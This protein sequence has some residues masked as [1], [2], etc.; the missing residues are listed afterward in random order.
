MWKPNFGEEKHSIIP[1]ISK[2]YIKA[3]SREC[4]LFENELCCGLKKGTIIEQSLCGADGHERWLW[5]Q[6][7]FEM[8]L[9]RS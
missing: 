6:R 8:D 9:Q 3:P 4:L 1:L 5:R 7:G 2:S